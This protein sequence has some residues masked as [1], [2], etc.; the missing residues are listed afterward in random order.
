[1]ASLL[2][3]PSLLAFL[4]LG[5]VILY[6]IVTLR[7]IRRKPALL[8]IPALVVAVLATL[9]Y[10]D[11]FGSVGVRNW[12]TRFSLSVV[13][14]LDLF[15]FR[16]FSSL[17]LAPYYYVQATT[18]PEAVGLVQS[19]LV[20]L[21][22]LFYC[23]I[24]TTSILT[25]HLFARRFASRLWLRFHRPSGK[26]RHVFFGENACALTLA[27]DLAKEKENQIL[28]IVFP[29]QDA[30]P[31]K[32]SF[33]QMLRGL[34][35]GTVRTQYIRQRVPGAVVLAARQALKDCPGEHL[36]REMGLAPLDKWTS[37]E[38]TS[39]YFL[40]DDEPQNIATVAMLPP[41]PGRIYCRADRGTLNDNLALVS[42]RDVK[43][44]DES[45]LT[46]KQMKMDPAFYPVNF[47]DKALDEAGE[48]AG[49][50]P[51]GFHAMVLGLGDI[52]RGILSFLYEFGT[53]VGEDG[54]AAPFCCEVV[55]RRAAR[56]SGTFR[57]EH[58]AIAPEKVRFTS[59][60]IGSDEFWR[61]F[62]ASLDTLNY[63]AIAL[64]DDQQNVRL[65]LD[66]LEMLCHKEL[67]RFPAIVVKLSEPGKY[68][69]VLD[70]YTRSLGVDCVRILGG[71]DAWTEANIIDET[72]ERHARA[73]YN[74]Y[75]KASAEPILWE[76]RIRK[77]EAAPTSPLWKKLEMRRKVGQDYSDYMHRKVKAALCPPRMWQDPA[78]ADSIPVV[79]AGSHSSDPAATPVLTC[80]AIGEHL[81]WQAAHEMD[82]YRCG[83]SKREDLK[84]HPA[85]Q[86][87][88]SLAEDIRHFDWIV[89]KT[90]L[91]L[92]HQEQQH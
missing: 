20:L 13:T 75:C 35:P 57:M 44:V 50:V 10:W 21:Y 41:C 77:I 4:V 32:L 36:F 15:L 2:D 69:K 43:L 86:D 68:R 14:A 34:R 5:G 8:W 84:I 64:G 67:R 89:V 7:I 65:A 23:A 55:D 9:L 60:D 90:T 45:F 27:A 79:Y 59:L 54:E 80:L 85:L 47:V 87:Y 91:Q 71:L 12:F 70:F 22:G 82:G 17:G 30:L 53:F 1:M 52:G 6:M 72:F 39:L 29:E 24:W 62:S 37:H 25:V 18:P 46:V 74:A 81:R 76:E 33:L 73:F 38:S 49:W 16:A 92:L 58:P 88:Q 42:E 31:A 66:M 51:G 78:V 56:L 40:S 11:A 26:H 61:H 19:H 63:V 3:N 48:P 28:F 83:P